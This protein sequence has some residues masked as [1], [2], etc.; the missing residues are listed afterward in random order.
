MRFLR[1]LREEVAQEAEVIR[2][3]SRAVAAADVLCGLAELA[4]HQGYCRPEMLPGREITLLM[5]VIR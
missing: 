1:R 5:V 2:N 3:L 4:V